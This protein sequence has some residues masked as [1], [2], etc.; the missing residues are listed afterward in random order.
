M[1]IMHALNPNLNP[2]AV[3]EVAGGN[4]NVLTLLL[5]RVQYF[6]AVA[7]TRAS[8]LTQPA[9]SFPFWASYGNL[10]RFLFVFPE[11]PTRCQSRNLQPLFKL[12]FCCLHR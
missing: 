6:G 11:L 10:P 7:K 1:E 12:P 3:F 9:D 2:K 8:I 5:E 4:Q